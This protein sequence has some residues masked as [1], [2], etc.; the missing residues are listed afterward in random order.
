MT[1]CDC[2]NPHPTGSDIGWPRCTLYFTCNGLYL[3]PLNPPEWI[4]WGSGVESCLTELGSSSASAP[5][6]IISEPVLFSEDDN[7]D[8]EEE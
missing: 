1:D 8:D 4:A 7:A 6:F 5:H 3:V 2:G